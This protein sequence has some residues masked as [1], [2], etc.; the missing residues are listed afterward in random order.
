MSWW[1][2][3]N[4]ERVGPLEEAE[5]SARARA[6]SLRAETLVWTD[7]MASWQPYGTVAPDPAA[8]EPSAACTEC[9]RRLGVSEL[10]R[11]GSSRVCAACKPLFLQKLREGVAPPAAG[12]RYA[13]FGVRFGAKLLD[14]VLMWIVNMAISFA[15]FGVLMRRATL[16]QGFLAMQ[17][18]LMAVELVVNAAYVVFFLGRFGATL[19]KMAL[20][21]R[22]VNPDGSPIS[23]GKAVGRYFAE[24]LS[25]LTLGIG[26]LM[27]GFDSERRALHDRVASTRVIRV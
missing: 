26:Y 15:F 23:Y 2:V 7:G 8:L 1:Y 18:A 22:V 4:G 27:A 11:Y 12:L 24:M 17:L 9:G 14:G 21:L 19:G 3:E 6:G 10:I 5:L 16:G 20:R 13:D 25:G